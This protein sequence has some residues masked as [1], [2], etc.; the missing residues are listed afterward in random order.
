MPR[1]LEHRPQP[2]P[3]SA[4]SV[5]DED[6]RHERRLLELRLM[7]LFT[8]EI[9]R[10]LPSTYQSENLQRWT[11]DVPLMALDHEPLRYAL[12][13][14]SLLYVLLTKKD[15]P[16]PVETVLAYRAEYSEGTL[17]RHRQA[18]DVLNADNADQSTYT[19]ALLAVDAL[20]CL[21]NRP[22]DPYEPPN[23]WLQMSQGAKSVAGTTLG[24]VQGNP[25][26]G[27]YSLHH[28]ASSICDLSFLCSEANKSYFPYLLHH[29]NP[30]EDNDDAKVYTDA[31]C[32]IAAADIARKAGEQ[33]SVL[34]RRIII[35]PCL[36]NPRFVQ[37]VS[38]RSPRALAILAHLFG[39]A[40]CVCDCWFIDET[41]LREIM[42]IER[43]LGSEWRQCMAWPMDMIRTKLNKEPLVMESIR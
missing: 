26:S 40:L 42:A 15:F 23:S 34:A 39:L 9:S 11:T 4:K 6:D 24:L 37:L 33:P 27:V 30:S 3:Q 35:F 21:R 29:F 22:L 17:T 38:L 2:A 10:T 18:L 19:S 43:Y 25:R 31:A 8:T 41:P 7:L 1:E 32:F 16:V 36:I 12:F 28:T 5:Q 20:A 13:S 14:I